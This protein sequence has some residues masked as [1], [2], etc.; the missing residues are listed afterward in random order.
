MKI[1]LSEKEISLILGAL[2]IAKFEGRGLDRFEEQ[3]KEISE[4]QRK[5]QK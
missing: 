5:L 1:E 3:E 2:S 4:L